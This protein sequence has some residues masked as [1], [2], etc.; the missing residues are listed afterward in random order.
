MNHQVVGHADPVGFHWVNLAVVVVV[1]ARLV[2]VAHTP[3]L[4]VG[5]RWERCA[6]HAFF[7]HRKPKSLALLSFLQVENVSNKGKLHGYILLCLV[8]QKVGAIKFKNFKLLVDFL[9]FIFFI[10]VV[11]QWFLAKMTWLSV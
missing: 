8:A 11:F 1:N 6:T 10:F 5:S 2:E 3:I 7:H 4:R 9:F